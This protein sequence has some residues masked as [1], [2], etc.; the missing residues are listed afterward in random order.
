MNDACICG[1]AADDHQDDG[2][3]LCTA[4]GC[5]CAGFE[6]DLEEDADAR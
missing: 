2:I 1:H 4:I 6:L 3:G 5:P